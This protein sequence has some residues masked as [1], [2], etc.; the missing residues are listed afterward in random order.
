MQLNIIDTKPEVKSVAIITPTV[1]SKHLKDCLDSVSRQTFGGVQHYI[2]IDGA[3]NESD[4]FGSVYSK[5]EP[6]EHQEFLCMLPENVGKAGGNWYGHRVYAAFSYLVN[7]DAVIFLDED[8]WLEPNHVQTLVDILNVKQT[9][10]AWSF[11]KIVDKEGN[12]LCD[13]NC[14]SLGVHAVWNND[15]VFHID[16]SS[17][18]VRR[19]VAVRVAGAWYGQ[20]GADR[21]YFSALAEHFP[22]ALPTGYH[23]LNYRLDGNPGSVT[24]EFFETGNAAMQ[25]RYGDSVLPFLVPPI[26]LL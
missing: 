11:R 9:D 2:V 23:T 22:N 19:D 8:N 1:G 20:W 12:Y 6:V 3:E 18:C 4:V 13:D 14:E 16:T 25:K 15:Q 26:P 17:Y 7:A 24:R 21:Q 5:R 10:W